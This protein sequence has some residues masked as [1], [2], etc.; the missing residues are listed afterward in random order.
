MRPDP[1]QR[2]GKWVV[3]LRPLGLGQ[4]YTLGPDSLSREDALHAAYELLA[5]LRGKGMADAPQ[6]TLFD[7]G[8]PLYVGALLDRWSDQKRY[9]GEGAARYGKTYAR[10]VRRELGEYKLTDF[11]PPAGHARLSAY[12]RSLEAANLSG[13]TIRNRLS[14]I[15]QAL[16]FAVESGWLDQV[17]LH[18]SLP[19]KALPVFRWITESMFR[20]LRGEVYR[21]VS[22][23]E[24]ARAGI[25]DAA[26]LALYVERRRVYLSW[27]FYT[28]VHHYDADHASADWL[29]LDGAAY[30]RHNHKTSMKPAQFEMPPQLLA[31]LRALETLL[32]RAFFPD[33]CFTGG[34]WPDCSRVMQRAARRLK[35]PHGASP[36]ILRRSYAREM[37]LRGY[38]V[39]EVADR[40]GHVDERMVEA[41]YT[42]TPRATGR[43]KSRWDLLPA[44]AP[45]PTVSGMARV[46]HL[47]KAE[48]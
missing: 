25:P 7:D 21:G 11:A 17:P 36:S 31:D 35:F 37:L 6:R 13:R 27:L 8:A 14:I 18:P 23:H 15:E 41:I 10:L 42:Q 19:P 20:A 3:D 44:S 24:M 12:A 46:L 34:P 32:G 39:R 38:S 28:G 29:F 48:S 5:R 9:Q 33:E 43:P 26:E 45:S 1:K 22:L 2:A 4:R 47:H 40:M 30:I 16:R